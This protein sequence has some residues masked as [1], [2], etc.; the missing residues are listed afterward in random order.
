MSTFDERRA[1]SSLPSFSGTTS[2]SASRWM[3]AVSPMYA[4]SFQVL[5]PSA[6]RTVAPKVLFVVLSSQYRPR[7]SD[8]S[9]SWRTGEEQ[10]NEYRESSLS[11][12]GS[13]QVL[14][15]SVERARR[16]AVWF[17]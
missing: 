12:I 8:P 17:V 4:R 9:A 1:A 10:A 14:P 13:L 5:P 6:D 11:W 3:P 15:L 2:V 7:I 16:T